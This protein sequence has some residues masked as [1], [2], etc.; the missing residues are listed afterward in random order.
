MCITR[1]LK[2][3]LKRVDFVIGTG[4]ADAPQCL[5]EIKA[6]DRLEDVHRVQTLSY[7]KASGLGIGL[8]VNFG[9]RKIEVCRI[10]NGEI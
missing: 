7:L 9:G 5:L 2:L 8:L 4:K 3:G 6:R 10:V 1:V